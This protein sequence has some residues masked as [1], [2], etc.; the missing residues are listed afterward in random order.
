MKN[1]A[2]GN[3][4]L[5]KIKGE[6]IGVCQNVS[7]D[8]NYDLQSVSGL[9]DVETQEHVVGH[10]T[11]QIS[12]EKYFVS[13]DTLRKLQIVPTNEEWLTAPE[14]EVEVIDT[15]SRSTVELYTGC[16]FNTHNRKYS[17]HR[18]TGEN[19]QIHARHKST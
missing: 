10:I 9:G 16:K 7:F 2:T 8:D 19:F 13:A 3:R 14:L 11:H 5:L 15:V 4:V 1:T 17:A 18:I 12:G 6:T